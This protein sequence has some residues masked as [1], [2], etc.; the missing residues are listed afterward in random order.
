[1]NVT[2]TLDFETMSELQEFLNKRGSAAV[3]STNLDAGASP[4]KL[5]AVPSPEQVSAAVVD[6]LSSPD[7]VE[8]EVETPEEFDAVL[9]REQLMTK[10][11]T[12]AGGMDDANVL[13]KFITNFGVARF[14]ELADD[15]LVGFTAA[16][17]SEFGV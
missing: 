16:L 10:L 7:P 17:K 11:K 15:Q 2:L 8:T 9:L 14:S 1:M 5:E 13:G 3:A 4:T 6:P 12:L